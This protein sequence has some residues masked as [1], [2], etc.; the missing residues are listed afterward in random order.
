LKVHQC[1][2]STDAYEQ[3]VKDRHGST[4]VTCCI[5]FK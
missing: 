5:K 4:H 2:G 1:F 3:T